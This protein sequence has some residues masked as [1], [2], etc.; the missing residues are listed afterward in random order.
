V[1]KLHIIHVHTTHYTCPYYTL[2][3]SILHITHVHTTHYTCPNYTLHITHVHT[4]HYTCPYYTLHM[5]KLHITHVHTTHLNM[6]V[7]IKCNY[8]D[9][10]FNNNYS[11]TYHTK[12]HHPE[13]KRSYNKHSSNS[14]VYSASSLNSS[15]PPAPLLLL[16][17]AVPSNIIVGKSVLAI[18]MIRMIFLS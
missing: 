4:T 16:E 18:T 9:L 10:T 14:S 13:M 8:C 11:K 5:S 3:M 7:R 12:L 17:D 2:H 15:R 1:S 6:S